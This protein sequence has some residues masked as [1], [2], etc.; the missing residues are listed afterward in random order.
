MFLGLMY[1]NLI[2]LIL[3]MA[4]GLLV[5]LFLLKDSGELWLWESRKVE[6]LESELALEKQK[7][8]ALE[9]AQEKALNWDLA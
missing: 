1:W 2:G 4:M 9:L 6:R 7:A 3:G 5:S 8:Q